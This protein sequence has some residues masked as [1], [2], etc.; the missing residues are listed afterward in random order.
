MPAAAT[1]SDRY[2]AV[3]SSSASSSSST[4]CY[5]N[6]NSY[7]S[8]QTSSTF[9]PLRSATSSLHLSKLINTDY[10]SMQ[11][12]KLQQQQYQT[13]R[14]HQTPVA[15]ISPLIKNQ[16]TDYHS[17]EQSWLSCEEL[18]TIEKRF[19]DLLHDISN[20]N[21]S[22]H[23]QYEQRAKS[24]D[25]LINDEP[26][27]KPTTLSNS[28][29]SLLD[30]SK[31]ENRRARSNRSHKSTIVSDND[32]LKVELS[33]RSIGT[34][35]YAARSL[36]D[37]YITTA[38]RLAKLEDWILFQHGLPVWLLN[39]GTNPKRQSCLSLVIA[40]YGSGFPVWQD[41]IGGH[42]DVKQAREQHITFRLSDKVTLAVLRFNNIL[43]SKE[44]FSY[45]VSIRNDHRYKH[46]FSNGNNRSS[47][48][49]SILT[50]KRKSHRHVNKSSISN[51]CQFQHITRLQVKDCAHL[52][53]LNRCLMSSDIYSNELL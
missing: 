7:S 12:L 52:T 50:S 3:S 53:T 13:N 1:A 45:Y 37:L 17:K 5:N 40:E 29:K 23:Q 28:R 6:L 47:S 27:P 51:P 46:L 19:T 36:C 42:S 2:S 25:R 11:S 31:D 24:C 16:Q 26:K 4:N 33:Y 34:H 18:E 22:N 44:F 21:T 41:N 20:K 32:I 49:G 38:E 8:S 10:R 39:S 48:C 43:A 15:R 9:S 30:K 14:M 35:V